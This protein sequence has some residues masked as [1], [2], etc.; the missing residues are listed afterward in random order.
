MV[1]RSLIKTN[2]QPITTLFGGF[3]FLDLAMYMVPT[4]KCIRLCFLAGMSFGKR[5]EPRKRQSRVKHVP[6]SGFRIQQT[7]KKVEGSATRPAAGTRFHFTFAYAC[8]LFRLWY[9]Y[10][11]AVR[12]WLYLRES[13]SGNYLGAPGECWRKTLFGTRMW[14]KALFDKK[15][16]E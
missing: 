9:L 8:E 1:K 14:W 7:I 12:V 3:L 13:S 11:R 6:N 10:A 16:Q 5:M 15:K 2:K 4:A